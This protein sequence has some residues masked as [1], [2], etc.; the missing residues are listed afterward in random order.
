MRIGAKVPN[1]GPLPAER[2]I[3]AMAVELEVA[4][5]ESLWVSDHVVMT[6]RVESRYP[7]AADGKV[8]WPSDTPYV[9]A[10]IA[11]AAIAT[12]TERAV[13]GTAVL[14][15]PQRQPVV[16]AKQAASIDVMSGG[17]LALGVG[18]GWLAEEFE[19]LNVPF[20][21]RGSRFTEWME[22][23]RACW[24]GVPAPFEGQHYR[25]PPGV[26]C[27]PTPAH[28]VPLLVG[29]HSKAAWR[30]AGEVGD[31]W[32]AHQSASALD[33]AELHVGIAASR[34]AAVRAG[35]HPQG[36]W[37]TLR[38]IDSATRTDVVADALVALAEAGVDEVVVDTDWATPGAAA[39]AFSALAVARRNLGR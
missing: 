13:I 33:V 11:L 10:M 4:G 36:L 35:R 37:T 2:G 7:F 8:T 16:L 28:H 15:L 32:L 18:A 21:S 19:A 9:D 26:R 6:E 25:L 12:A 23:L 39:E 1:S 34:D 29:G 17:R 22:L 5:F 20:A 30:R 14:V 27:V 3:A 24:T 38:I 31:G